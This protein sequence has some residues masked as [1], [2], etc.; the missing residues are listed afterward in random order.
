MVC[1]IQ[2]E[3]IL[4]C[5]ETEIE[6]KIFNTVEVEKSADRGFQNN[7]SVDARLLILKKLI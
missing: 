6:L 5:A 3:V 1:L 7:G 4:L 2:E